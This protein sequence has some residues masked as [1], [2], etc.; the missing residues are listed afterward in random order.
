MPKMLKL[1]ETSEDHYGIYCPLNC[2]TLSYDVNSGLICGIFGVDGGDNDFI[3][4][5]DGKVIEIRKLHCKSYAEFIVAIDVYNLLHGVEIPDEICTTDT[6]TN[7]VLKNK[8]KILTEENR[9]LKLKLKQLKNL[10]DK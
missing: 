1:I 3:E 7:N 4:S 9:Q 8:V 6:K 10:I 5:V 2:A